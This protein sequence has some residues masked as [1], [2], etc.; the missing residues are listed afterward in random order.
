[1]DRSLP[2]VLERVLLDQLRRDTAQGV[3][4]IEREAY[5]DA[6]QLLVD[7]HH[8][9]Q[10]AG[11]PSPFLAWAA[12]VACD[13]CGRLDEAMGLIDEAR[14]LD[15]LSPGIDHSWTL[16]ARKLAD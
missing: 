12:A 15:V 10:A 8:A 2:A 1:M 11:I 6:M 14:R 4:L 16:I 7:A 13:H 3:A 5:A 9:A